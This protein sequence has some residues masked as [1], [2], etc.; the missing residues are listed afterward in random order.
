MFKQMKSALTV[1]AVAAVFL[2]CTGD[3]PKQRFANEAVI[4]VSPRRIHIPAPKGFVD[5]ED[6]SPQEEAFK[7]IEKG[8][9]GNKVQGRWVKAENGE[10]DTSQTA[11]VLTPNAFDGKYMS[12][13]SFASGRATFR[14]EMSG[15][16]ELVTKG[17]RNRSDFL[18]GEQSMGAETN[19]SSTVDCSVRILPPHFE[20]R[21]RIGNTLIIRDVKDVGEGR[22]ESFTVNSIS[23]LWIRG[24]V[25]SLCV[26]QCVEDEK[27]VDGA[28]AATRDKLKQWIAAVDA[29]NAREP[30]NAEDELAK[31][32]PG[33]RLTAEESETESWGRAGEFVAKGLCAL[34]LAFL[35]K[36]TK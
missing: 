21:D 26:L 28:V 34:F 12:L 31:K 30:L 29:V 35:I 27:D 32:N 15:G 6:G 13:D 5:L 36:K 25:F 1:V 10:L 3:E 19:V 33:C 18:S 9:E 7:R 8:V 11:V 22:S 14:K 23:L 20:E 24:T 2:S 4:Y 16:S 17:L